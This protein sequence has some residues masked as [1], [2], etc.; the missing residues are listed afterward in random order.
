[1][2][3]GGE[4]AAFVGDFRT[5]RRAAGEDEGERR[6][7]VAVAQ[8]GGLVVWPSGNLALS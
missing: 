6:G 4:D 2:P 3:A 7:V 5:V 1:M 8:A